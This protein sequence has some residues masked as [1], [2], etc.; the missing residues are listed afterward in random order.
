MKK[1]T[2]KEMGMGEGCDDVFEGETVMDIAKA[3]HTHFMNSTD[4]AHK[5]GREM[6]IKG[7]NKEE[8]DKWWAWFNGEWKKKKEI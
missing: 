3:C 1:F 4:L 2:C 7:P 6:M 5:E 8:Q